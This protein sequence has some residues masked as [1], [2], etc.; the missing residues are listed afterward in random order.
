MV[1]IKER[2]G[3]MLEYLKDQIYPEC[4]DREVSYDQ[5]RSEICRCGES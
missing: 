3:K 2:I 4:A 5:N 1:L